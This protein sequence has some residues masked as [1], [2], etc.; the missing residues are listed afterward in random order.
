MTGNKNWDNWMEIT[1]AVD[2]ARGL[3]LLADLNCAESI[4]DDEDRE[5]AK[6]ALVSSISGLLQKAEKLLPEIEPRLSGEAA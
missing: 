2:D 1:R 6:R 4:V 5:N 3:A